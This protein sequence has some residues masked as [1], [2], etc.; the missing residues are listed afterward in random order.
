MKSGGV[1][2]AVFVRVSCFGGDLLQQGVAWRRCVLCA[3]QHTCMRC[4]LCGLVVAI[5]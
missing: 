3:V 1:C 4:S 2:E 5:G